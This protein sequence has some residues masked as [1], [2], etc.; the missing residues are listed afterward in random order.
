M[1]A[2]PR[3]LSLFTTRRCTAACDHC[4]IGASPRATE[5]LSLERMHGLI[6]EASCS[7]FERVV[8]TGGECFL[9]G[10]ELDKLVAHANVRG[11][12]TRT[13]TNGYWAISEKAAT[14]RIDLLRAAGLDELMLSTGTFHERFVPAIRVLHAAR[15]AAT[16][17]IETHVSIEEC[18]QSTFDDAL[19]RDHLSDLISA[20]KVS[21]SKDPW[22]T[23]PGGRGDAAI[24]NHGLQSKQTVVDGPCGQILDVVSVTP[25]GMLVACCGFPI[26]QLPALSLGSVAE[27]PLGD[28]LTSAPNQLLHMWL[29]SRG[30]AD[31]AK[32]VARYVPGYTLPPAASICQICE[33]L[34]S[35]PQA[36]AVVFEHAGDVVA[37]IASEF[38]A[39][40]PPR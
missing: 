38:V 28:V 10:S 34:Q 9:L 32:F 39:T 15:A 33:T 14:T 11:L 30:P 16:A 21:I 29:R 13:I 26:E 5:A 17:G 18:D 7:Q 12:T 37:E 36:M 23:D 35:N 31:I 27:R 24:T 4:A 40:Q 6:E 19:F 8:F 1:L 20:G 3:I 25:D 2:R 22:I